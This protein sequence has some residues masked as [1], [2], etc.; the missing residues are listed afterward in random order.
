MQHSQSVVLGLC[1]K[2]SAC[3]CVMFKLRQAYSAH[4]LPLLF[5]STSSH[6]LGI[7]GHQHAWPPSAISFVISL[8]VKYMQPFG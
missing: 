7:T 2:I 6:I 5:S 4:T 1:F 3:Y 8:E